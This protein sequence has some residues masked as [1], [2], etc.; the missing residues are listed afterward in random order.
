MLYALDIKNLSKKYDNNFYLDNLN[1]S[2]P[3]GHIMGL[4]G[5]NGAGKTTTINLI[6]NEI[7]RDNGNICIYGNDVLKD[8]VKVKNDIGI[9][10]DECCLPDLFTIVE[11][12]KFIRKIYLHWNHELYSRYISLFQ[13]PTNKAIKEFSKGMKVKLN[14]AI[15][16]SHNAKLLILDEPTSG[17]DPV[18]RDDVLDILM[19]F[20]QDNSHSILFSSHITNDL[21]KIADYIAFIHNGKLIFCKTKDELIYNYGIIHCNAA[22]FNKLD[23]S[24]IVAYRKFDCEWQVLTNNRTLAQAKYPDSIVDAASID[25]VMLLYIKGEKK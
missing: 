16:L 8:E 6:L 2:L 17:L 13:L 4:V 1:L 14:L 25:D 5:Q 19:D 23:S 24:D 18:V 7:T 3:Q 12:E 10:F 15:A 9:V 21:S 11:I 20:V 22:S